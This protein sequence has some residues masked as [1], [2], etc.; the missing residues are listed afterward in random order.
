[1]KKFQTVF[2]KIM[3][4]SSLFLIVSGCTF[5]QDLYPNKKSYLSKTVLKFEDPNQTTVLTTS[6][7]YNFKNQLVNRVFSD[8]TFNKRDNTYFPVLNTTDYVYNEAGF[9]LSRNIEV[10]STT[11]YLKTKTEYQYQNSLLSKEITE[12]REISYIYDT[13]GNLTKVISK[14][15]SNGR[16]EI[17]EYEGSVP[18]GFTK[19][20]NGFIIEDSEKKA[21]YNQKLL[22]EKVE[23]FRNGI[24]GF[25]EFYQYPTSGLP[26]EYLPDFKGFPEI[27]SFSYRNSLDQH[28]RKYRI[29][30][31]SE[32]LIE[33][34]KV[35]FLADNNGKIIEGIGFEN[36]AIGSTGGNSRKLNFKYI[37]EDR[38]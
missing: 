21:F 33:E 37:Y 17:T 2:K 12:T 32:T 34:K 26:F 36:L 23:Y 20:S 11:T 35:D 16:E 4:I 7:T 18:K 31:G 28:I 15:K 29:Q 6:Y 10:L 22:L 3:G 24:L 5:F 25:R 38:R 19:V 1:M 8:T 13:A 27:K 9:L 30:N 14:N